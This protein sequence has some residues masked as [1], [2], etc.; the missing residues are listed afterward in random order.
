[1]ALGG[2]GILTFTFLWRTNLAEKGIVLWTLR[3]ILRKT[4]LFSI[5]RPQFYIDHTLHPLCL[6]SVRDG[7]ADGLKKGW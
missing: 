2:A 4:I 7:E 1:M 3:T 5:E 6:V